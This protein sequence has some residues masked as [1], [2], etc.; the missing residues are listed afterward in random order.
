MS[1]VGLVLTLVAVLSLGTGVMV[2]KENVDHERQRF[3]RLERELA[4]AEAATA[5]LQ[6]E[7]AYHQRLAYLARFA[8]ALGLV[9]ARPTQLV[10]LEAV[11]RRPAPLAAGEPAP[12]LV[13]LPSGRRIGLARRPA[14][15][16]TP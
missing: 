11:P 1:G 3:A 14:P 10:E 12:L 13:A 15:D 6:A 7:L 8:R 16:P 5:R 2:F 9:P 4:A